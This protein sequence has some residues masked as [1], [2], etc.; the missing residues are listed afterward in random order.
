LINDFI[1]KIRRLIVLLKSYL[2]N[3]IDLDNGIWITDSWK[4]ANYFHWLTDFLPKTILLNKKY[5]NSKFLLPKSFLRQAP[6]V[7][8]SL[9]LLEINYEI[10]NEKTIY[11]LQNLKVLN[12]YSITGNQRKSLLKELNKSL[13]K[14]INLDQ[15]LAYINEMPNFLYITRKEN[16]NN[17][18]SSRFI[19]NEVEIFPILKK[20]NIKTISCEDLSFYKQLEI[21]S[22]CN[23]LISI[24][25]AGLTNMIFMRNGG[26]IL[27][28]R[29]ENDAGSNCYFSMAS[30]LG[31]DYYYLCGESINNSNI[32]NANLYI[33]TYKFSKL[34][35]D[36]INK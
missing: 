10:I 33:D 24:H 36:I 34:L 8:S 14:I 18:S 9:D 19:E 35:V 28:L 20:F 32:Y 3:G 26:S 7:L 12:N 4:W 1:Y 11:N 6:F 25:G 17:F 27:E 13:R 16:K 22:S 5:P 30:S 31:L 15:K 2:A 29:H 21:F 23:F